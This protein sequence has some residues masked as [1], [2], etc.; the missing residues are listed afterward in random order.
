MTH[1]RHGWLTWYKIGCV[2][3][4]LWRRH[5]RHLGRRLLVGH[6]WHGL[7]KWWLWLK[8]DTGVGEGHRGLGAVLLLGKLWFGSVHWLSWG[9]HTASRTL[10][11]VAACW[12][13]HHVRVLRDEPA[14]TAGLGSAGSEP[15]AKRVI[16]TILHLEALSTSRER[17]GHMWQATIGLGL[18]WCEH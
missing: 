7:L 5:R 14:C 17:T 10:R 18:R 4:N 12:H 8:T 16:V 3:H 13:R 15:S 1:R 9:P 6:E 11:E 2:W